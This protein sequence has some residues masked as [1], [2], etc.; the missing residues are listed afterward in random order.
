MRRWCAISYNPCGMN[1]AATSFVPFYNHQVM[2][3][4]DPAA[5][6]GKK[7]GRALKAAKPHAKRLAAEAKPRVEKARDDALKFARE[8]EDE[9][10]QF[11][12]KLV[13]ARLRGP[14]GMVFDAL[15]SQPEDKP[16]T[17]R[18]CPSCEN[19]NPISA[20]F[21]GKCGSALENS[22]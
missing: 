5:E 9:G 6:L 19:A 3:K 15:A 21:C 10:K 22:S 8:H 17:S 20:K 2:D 7:L 16:P 13:R 12:Q 18:Q 11:A 1:P 4:Q 14:L